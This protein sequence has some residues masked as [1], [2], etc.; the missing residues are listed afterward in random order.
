MAIRYIIRDVEAFISYVAPRYEPSI[1]QFVMSVIDPFDDNWLKV[2]DFISSKSYLD[3]RM[4]LSSMYGFE[5]NNKTI[6]TD[7]ICIDW[8]EIE[9]EIQGGL[10]QCKT[11][12]DLKV[13][14]MPILIKLNA[15][16]I[17]QYTANIEVIMA[18]ESANN[19]DLA[20]CFDF[21]WYTDG[22]VSRFLDVFS[23]C[24]LREYYS[25]RWLIEDMEIWK[26]G[27]YLRDNVER[28]SLEDFFL[29]Q[30]SRFE[31]EDYEPAFQKTVKKTRMALD[32]IIEK[33]VWPE[34]AEFPVV[35]TY[36]GFLQNKNPTTDAPR[37]GE[38]PARPQTDTTPDDDRSGVKGGKI[39]EPFE[40][41]LMGT[42][43][44]KRQ[45]LARLHELIK[46]KKGRDAIT[47]IVAANELGLLW[48]PSFRQFTLEFG[49]ITSKT[50]YYHAVGKKHNLALEKSQLLQNKEVK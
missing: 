28:K 38:S 20:K 43:E 4:A 23:D 46:G 37:P 32:N 3:E 44:E 35:K 8:G 17:S 31:D 42:E 12:R 25:I 9:N 26:S 10:K 30:P 21:V 15:A 34:S 11:S 50:N 24:L 49:D 7:D 19:H 22:I 45:T 14:A 27:L 16:F 1:T 48:I 2:Q 5:F 18:K 33:L 39:V 6:Y 41:C 13:Y 29:S 40:A 36:S 47:Y